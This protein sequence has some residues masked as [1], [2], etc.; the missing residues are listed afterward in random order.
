MELIPIVVGCF[1]PRNV[2][3]ALK[4][5]EILGIKQARKWGTGSLNEFRKFFGLKEYKT[6]EEINSDPY[7]VEQ[8]RNLYEHPDNVELYPGIVS[9]DPKIPMVPGAGICPTYTLSRA[10]LSDA[11]ALVRGDR[12]YTVSLS[13]YVKLSK[14]KLNVRYRLTSTPRI[15]PTGD[16]QSPI[17][18]YPSIRVACST[19]S[20]CAH[21]R[22]RLSRTRV[23]LTTQ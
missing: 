10:I 2:P 13:L 17:M 22:T 8:L 12:F 6:F 18:T 7:V 3:K 19:S 15:S 5:V 16:S 9:E 23:M 21:C 14:Q 20:C 4:A 1:G 11:V